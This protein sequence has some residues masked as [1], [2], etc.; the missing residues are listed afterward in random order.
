M[1][2][3]PWWEQSTQEEK[4]VPAQLHC[5][6][7]EAAA[8]EKDEE[9]EEESE[10]ESEYEDEEEEEAV[11]K[12]NGKKGE[13]GDWE[14]GEWEYYDDDEEDEEEEEDEEGVSEALDAATPRRMTES[15]K[16]DRKEWIIQ[17]LLQIIPRAPV[18]AK[19]PMDDDTDDEDQEDVYE[20]ARA[21][22]QQE[23]LKINQM[24]EP[25][26]K[27]YK[28]WLEE[29]AGELKENGVAHSLSQIMSPMSDEDKSLAR[30]LAEET[31]IELTEEQKKTRSKAAKIVDK[32]KS[33]EGAELKKVLF[34]LKTFFQ[35]DKSLVS[36][37]HRA[38]GLTQL[39]A[40]GKEDEAQL[41][42]FILRALGQIM[43][44]VDGMQVGLK[45]LT[46]V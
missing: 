39:V 1:E 16:D 33:T 41:Q 28:D 43:L 5:N 29:A 3:K 7:E 9:K 13:E 22:E 11:V 25:E 38:G 10:W 14:E 26:S 4:E 32:L 46:Q 17:G 30:S 2:E 34:S 35:E 21:G 36:E 15:E 37:F 27:G 23:E 31:I 12:E 6:Q 42:N 18:R 44:Y 45:H 24:V 8:E 20:D 40:L 19:E